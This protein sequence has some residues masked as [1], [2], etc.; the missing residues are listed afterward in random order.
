MKRSCLRLATAIAVALVASCAGIPQDD[1]YQPHD[2]GRSN[3]RADAP[4][5]TPQV[6]EPPGLTSLG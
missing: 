4:R 1:R 5:A 6:M 3:N 2:G